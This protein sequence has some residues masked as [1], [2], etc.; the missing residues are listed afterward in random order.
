MQTVSFKASPEDILL[1]DL[2]S[3]RLNLSMKHRIRVLIFAL[4]WLQLGSVMNCVD[5]FAFSMVYM[6]KNSTIAA[7]AGRDDV[8]F[9]K[10][11]TELSS[12]DRLDPMRFGSERRVSRK[13][14][15][16]MDR[17]GIGV[18]GG[19]RQLAALA[20][21]QMNSVRTHQLLFL[22]SWWIW[23]RSGFCSRNVLETAEKIMGN[24]GVWIKVHVLQIYIYTLEEKSS[25]ISAMAIGSLIGMYPQNTLMNKYG[26]R[27]VLTTASLLCAVVTV[28]L[29]WA[30]DTNYHVALVFRILQGVLYSADFG[31]VGY[32]CS[33]WA[34]MSEVG[35]SIA[36]LSGFTAARAVI[37]L[38][39]AGW[40]SSEVQ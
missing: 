32:V 37:Q 35:I 24:K 10:T 2:F 15:G 30:L 34:P 5:V 9:C 31:V 20:R 11:P 27:V 28:F 25:L 13:K 17:I 7:E 12:R 8:S 33:R 21:R 4:T 18:G 14:R 16:M 23:I 6:E 40:V 29:P 39:L 22:M 38:P 1:T 36:A 3:F 19:G 26:P